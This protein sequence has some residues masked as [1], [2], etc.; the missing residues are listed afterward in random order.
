MVAD[1]LIRSGAEDK[2]LAMI[3]KM[4]EVEVHIILNSKEQV[5]LFMKIG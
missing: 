3:M 2:G 5:Y 1:L 4:P